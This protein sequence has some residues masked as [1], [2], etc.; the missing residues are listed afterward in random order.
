MGFA[1]EIRR[2]AKDA[3]TRESAK[4]ARA[5][6]RN[7]EMQRWRERER[8]ARRA[9]REEEEQELAAYRSVQ[10]FAYELVNALALSELLSV[11][12]DEV[13]RGRAKLER[14][15]GESAYS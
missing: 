4:A 12:N 15:C 10:T 11:I 13:F 14:A 2:A 9:A 3:P 5:K 1:E 7:D 8:G 6:P